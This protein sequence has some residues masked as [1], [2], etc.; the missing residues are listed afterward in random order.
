MGK[1]ARTPSPSCLRESEAD[2]L[3]II[4]S[5][6]N[7]SLRGTPSSRQ[8]TQSPGTCSPYD[9]LWVMLRF[10][11]THRLIR[12]DC[13]PAIAEATLLCGHWTTAQNTGGRKTV[14]SLKNFMTPCCAIRCHRRA[15]DVLLLT[16]VLATIER[17]TLLE[18][19]LR[20]VQGRQCKKNR[21]LITFIPSVRRR[22]SK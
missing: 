12:C 20:Q 15:S 19:R 6:S 10:E 7:E 21:L 8:T 5:C 16:I 22:P 2:V 9:G 11:G 4:G 1:S 17:M 14:S 3:A 18:P 13:T